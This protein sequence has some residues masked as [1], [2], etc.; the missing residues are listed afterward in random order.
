MFQNEAK[1]AA[2]LNHPNVVQIFDFGMDHERHYMA[3]EYI[4]G[5]NLRRIVKALKHKN[6]RFPLP[7]VLRI[8]A[9]TCGALEYAH[10]LTDT[11]GNPLS[12]IHRDVSLE[13]ILLTYSGQVKLVDFGIAKATILDSYTTEGTLKGKYSYMAPELIHGE[14]PDRRI[15]IYAVGVVLY[16]T[17]LGRLPFTANNQA[18]LL[19]RIIRQPAPPPRA[20]DPSLPVELERILLKALHKDREQRYQRAGELQV[21]LEGYLQ[22]SG[23]V[24]MTSQLVQFMNDTFPAGSDEDRE[25]YQSLA[26]GLA[27]TPSTPSRRQEAPADQSQTEEQIPLAATLPAPPSALVGDKTQV[28]PPSFDVEEA[29]IEGSQTTER[30]EPRAESDDLQDDLELQVFSRK[31]HILPLALAI[32]ALL[33]GA[34]IAILVMRGDPDVKSRRPDAGAVV[35]IEA[36]TSRDSRAASVEKPQAAMDARIARPSI[37]SRAPSTPAKPVPPVV[38]TE[39]YLT[40][41]A[42]LP[43]VA[44]LNGRR[45]G[46]LPLLKRP[47]SRGV[48]RLVVSGRRP[49]YRVTRRLVV[50]RGQHLR[51]K[52][53]PRRG[54]IKVMARPWAKVTLDGKVLGVTPISP[55]SVYEGNHLLMLENKNLRARRRLSIVVKPGQVRVVKVKM[56]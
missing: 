15:D 23:M 40:I 26:G 30:P 7:I 47:L 43:G 22:R 14:T 28:T 46:P 45:L 6:Q 3:M 20:I 5:R 33:C 32:G 31:R 56:N 39:G 16:T 25:A 44:S 1:L 13:N 52:I 2:L 54:R 18:Q 53:E 9:D 37:D 8:I 42:R 21:E 35:V 10:S 48:Y 38:R 34:L 11:A 50:K 36:P 55:V 49:R 41:K 19:D 17:L 12:I 29:Q 4:D 24:M 27:Y 51:I